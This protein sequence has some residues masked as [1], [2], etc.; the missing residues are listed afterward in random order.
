MLV[1]P[2]FPVHALSPLPLHPYG[3]RRKP[4]TDQCLSHVRKKNPVTATEGNTSPRRYPHLATIQLAGIPSRRRAGPPRPIVLPMHRGCPAHIPHAPNAIHASP[5][6]KESTQFPRRHPAHK[7]T[8]GPHPIAS[9]WPPPSHSSHSTRQPHPY[10]VMLE[11]FPFYTPDP[12]R[13][14]D[15]RV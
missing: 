12:P 14:C 3:P 7:T 10:L 6:W 9:A 11:Y 1:S 13:S 8:I 2:F 15:A 5:P 4:L